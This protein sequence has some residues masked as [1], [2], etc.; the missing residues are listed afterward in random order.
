MSSQVLRTWTVLG[1]G[2][3]LR[4]RP[5]Q[6][7]QKSHHQQRGKRIQAIAEEN[8]RFT[9]AALHS[10]FIE[11]LAMHATHARIWTDPDRSVLLK[12]ST[13]GEPD[14]TRLLPF[15]LAGIALLNEECRTCES[16]F[17]RPARESRL[18]VTIQ[19]KESVFPASP[20]ESRLDVRF[21]LKYPRSPC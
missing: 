12:E 8:V 19:P 6:A 7:Q 5:R 18:G 10:R 16:D 1:R 9:P 15:P 11:Y 20:R 3:K 14:S 17:S 21:Q 13:F 2:D 4:F